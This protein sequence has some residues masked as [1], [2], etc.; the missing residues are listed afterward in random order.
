MF[1]EVWGCVVSKLTRAVAKTGSAWMASM[2]WSAVPA[3]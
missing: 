3:S 1:T 2:S